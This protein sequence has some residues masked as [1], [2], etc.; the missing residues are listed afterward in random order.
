[1]FTRD[2]VTGAA[3]PH[4]EH[5]DNAGAPYVPAAFGV[6]APDPQILAAE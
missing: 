2:P 6:A 1:V 4:I 3:S 5:V